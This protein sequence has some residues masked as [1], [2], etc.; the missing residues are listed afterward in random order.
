MKKLLLICLLGLSFGLKAQNFELY[1]NGQRVTNGGTVTLTY[2]T[3]PEEVLH[4]YAII[5]NVGTEKIRITGTR[6]VDALADTLKDRT[7][8]CIMGGCQGATARAQS[9]LAPGEMFA[10]ETEYFG[11]MPLGYVGEARVTYTLTTEEHP[12]TDAMTFNVVWD[13][14]EVPTNR[15]NMYLEGKKIEDGHMYEHEFALTDDPD[16]MFELHTVFENP[17]KD[18]VIIYAYKNSF[19]AEGVL[20]AWCMLGNCWE[21]TITADRYPLLPESKIESD[22]DVQ[23][24]LDYTPNG[25]VGVGYVYYTFYDKNNPANCLNFAVAWKTTG[26]PTTANEKAADALQTAVYPNP[27]TTVA[28]LSWEAV[29]GVVVLNV[30]NVNGQLLY[31][32]NVEG[33]T[34]AEINVA[35]FTPG[36][37]FYTLERQG[38][39]LGSGKLLVR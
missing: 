26:K 15:M 12:E 23:H 7:L 3:D 14:R 27:A 13:L 38:E 39:R 9:E 33:L 20:N 8:W 36:M 31:S 6:N 4:A 17:S 19:V 37:Y 10:G 28:R 21:E 32:R 11:I 34:E 35:G 16:E 22:D 29:E 30:R 2:A 5:K 18:T 25:Y 1:I 24:Y